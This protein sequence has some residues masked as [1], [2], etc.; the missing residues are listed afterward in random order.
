[1]AKAVFVKSARKDN[2]AAGVK[3]GDSYWWASFRQ[4]RSSF[5]RYWKT[6]PSRSDLTQSEFYSTIYALEDRGFYGECP[7]DLQNE[8]DE[9]VS[10]LN[11]LA[12]QCRDSLSAMPDGLQQG[13][14]GQMLEARADGCESTASEFEQI[15]LDD[16]DEDGEE[17]LE[18]WCEGKRQELENVGFEYE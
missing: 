18:D 9:M 3:K 17:S 16:F 5:K 10:E 7:E 6:K 8:R 14:T 13:D 2:K 1:M 4:G 15:D 11:E 12:D